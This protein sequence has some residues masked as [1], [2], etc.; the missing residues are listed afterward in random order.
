M[1]PCQFGVYFCDS[2]YRVPPL[3]CEGG[4]AEVASDVLELPPLCASWRLTLG[5]CASVTQ[6]SWGSWLDVMVLSLLEWAVW[7]A[8]FLF[9]PGTLGAKH[10]GDRSSWGT[11]PPLVLPACVSPLI[12]LWDVEEIVGLCLGG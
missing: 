2:S 5:G 10:G 4:A 7:V 8:L 6:V 3:L 1:C 11:W 9:F 12:P